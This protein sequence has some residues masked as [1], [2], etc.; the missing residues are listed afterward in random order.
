MHSG[1]E[2]FD[3]VHIALP[4]IIESHASNRARDTAIVC[5]D[6]RLSWE[7]FDSR[8]NA[9]ANVLTACGIGRDERVVVLGSNSIDTIVAI[10]GTIKAGACVVPLSTMLSPD[11]L[12][13][14]IA[15]AGTRMV[16]V[17]QACEALIAAKRE[18]ITSVPQAG[19]LALDFAADG[20]RSYQS[21]AAQVQS[22]HIDRTYDPSEPCIIIYSSGTTGLPKGIVHSHYSRHQLAH[23]CALEMRFNCRS[24]AL[25]TTSVYSMGTF[26]MMLP[27]LF[28]G[29]TLIV[30]PKFSTGGFL[31]LVQ[32]ERVTHSFMVPSQ[33]TMLFNEQVPVPAQLATI[34][35]LLSAGSPLRP[36]LKARILEQITPNLFELYGNSEGFATMLKPEEQAEHG[37]TVG[38]PFIGYDMRI[39]GTDSNVVPP[40]K[41]GEIVGYGG[42]L[43]TCYHNR[44]EETAQA[45]WHHSSRRTFVRTGDIGS[46]DNLGFLTIVDRKKDMI[47]SGGFNVFPVDIEKVISLHEA[48]LDVAVIGIPHPKWDETPFAFVIR[49]SGH[50]ATADELLQWVNGRVART[51]RVYGIEFV[52]EF[53]R[54]ALGKVLKRV[55]RETYAQM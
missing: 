32:T 37:H 25:T 43:M 50:R 41:A 30:M 17:S 40:G 55:L 6:V 16:C 28:V 54:N 3:A 2:T 38:R 52:E 12:A 24:R 15:D 22:S 20:W 46:V 53:P 45:I 27:V 1:L 31:S 47:I 36:E 21:L 4:Q 44:P 11:Q 42:S 49:R 8:L 5:G 18:S 10:F 34:E 51:Q 35:C 7:E 14:M 23:L 26:L 39:I 13:V 19:W 33:F 9:F 29:G 48:V